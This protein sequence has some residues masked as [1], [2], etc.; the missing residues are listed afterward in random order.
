MVVCTLGMEPLRKY[1]TIDRSLQLNFFLETG[2]PRATQAGLE[3]KT[4]LLLPPTIGIKVCATHPVF[5]DF[6]SSVCNGSYRES[7]NVNTLLNLLRELP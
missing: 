3:L 2:S 5:T 1:S 7:V 4:F 6:Y